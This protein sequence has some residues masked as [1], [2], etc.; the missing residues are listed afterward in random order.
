MTNWWTVNAVL[1]EL[2]GAYMVGR[3]LSREKADQSV[4]AVGLVAGASAP[5]AT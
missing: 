4:R 2:I 1:T 3:G 5:T